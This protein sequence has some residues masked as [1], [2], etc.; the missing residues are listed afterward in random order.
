MAPRH[1]IPSRRRVPATKVAIPAPPADLVS[2][3]RLLA[4]LDR[5][6]EAAVVFVGAPA[7]FG[8]TVLL[9]DWARRR[10]RGA[11]AWL[12]AG[13]EDDDDRFFWSAVLE[14]L[15]RCPG[16]PAGNPLRLLAVPR[17]PSPDLAFLARVADSIDVLP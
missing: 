8:K 11:V 4:E 14:A 9:A 6:R 2:R 7:G 15:G 3:P 17:A 13:A 16:V 1:D 12:S 5:A 10:G